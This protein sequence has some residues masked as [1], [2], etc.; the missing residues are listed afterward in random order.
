[1][2]ILDL[3]GTSMYDFHYTYLKGRYGK[4]AELL[5][6]DTDSSVYEIETN[7]L[8]EDFYRNKDMFDFSEYQNI[9]SFTI[10]QIKK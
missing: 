2:C 3:T 9:Q 7:D 6:T 10:Q 1:M 5:F 8:Y 4:K